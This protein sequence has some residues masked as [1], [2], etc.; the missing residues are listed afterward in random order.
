MTISVEQA[1]RLLKYDDLAP[2]EV[3]RGRTTITLPP[4]LHLEIMKI[5]NFNKK[6]RGEV[7]RQLCSAVIFAP[8][9]SSI[10]R[11]D[12]IGRIKDKVRPLTKEEKDKK[13]FRAHMMDEL[14]T[15]LKK[16]R[17]IVEKG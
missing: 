6:K 7:I 17:E 13:V 15:V 16:R 9:G 10:G 14:Q 2:I 12:V 3:G 11:N 1:K 5:C 8:A 4:N